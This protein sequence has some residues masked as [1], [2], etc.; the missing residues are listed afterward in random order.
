MAADG[1][2][3][4]RIHGRCRRS[5]FRQSLPPAEAGVEADLDAVIAA[6]EANLI[7]RIAERVAPPG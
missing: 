7:V 1:S 6:G 2:F 4:V 5:G 3:S